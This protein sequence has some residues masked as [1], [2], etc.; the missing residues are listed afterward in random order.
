[1]P[2]SNK[3]VSRP[4]LAQEHEKGFNNAAEAVWKGMILCIASK[5]FNVPHRMLSI[6]EL[7]SAV[8]YTICI[9]LCH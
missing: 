7:F 9:Q 3:G 4:S 6:T 5:N 1:M 8:V 2:Q